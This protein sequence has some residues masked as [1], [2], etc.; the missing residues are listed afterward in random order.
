MSGLGVI[1]I[2]A[3]GALVMLFVLTRILGKKQISQLTFFEYVTG[4]VIGDLAGFMSTDVEADYAHGVTAL[5]I[6]FAIPLIAE[7]L[8]L[9]SKKIR[10]LLEGKGTVF[11]Q[12][13]RILEKNLRKE[14]YT[15]DE[16]MEQLRTKSV[17]NPADVEFAIL[18]ASGDLSVLLKEDK[19]PLT[20]F[21]AGLALKRTLPPQA[22]I[23]D[24][25]IQES[26]LQ[27]LG[28]DKKWLERQIRKTGHST[29]DVFLAVADEK[30]AMYLD[31][32]KDSLP[33]PRL[34][35]VRRRKG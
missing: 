29:K 20:P 5:L 33:S 26:G 32:Y 8:A 13:G 14:R 7:I 2:R 31:Y 18:E 15:S 1:A 24:G 4:I 6:W 21:D 19:Q 11:I 16:L 3:L 12:D 10:V 9:K 34:R 27:F 35:R 23:M 28:F 22:V 17:F 25:S 30:G